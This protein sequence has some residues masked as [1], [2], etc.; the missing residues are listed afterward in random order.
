MELQEEEEEEEE[1]EEGGPTSSVAWSKE[2][3]SGRKMAIV[4]RKT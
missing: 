1:E 2:R 4:N 3:Q